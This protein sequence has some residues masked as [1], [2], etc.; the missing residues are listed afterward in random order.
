[1]AQGNGS[2]S[3]NSGEGAGQHTREIDEEYFSELDSADS[4]NDEVP[5]AFETDI[6]RG[7]GKRT[8]GVIVNDL[9]AERRL[10]NAKL[11]EQL[12]FLRSILPGT[13]P[14]VCSVTK[15]STDHSNWTME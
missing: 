12:S 9:H 3:H 6:P 15:T 13:T 14:G 8:Y 2:S 10:K 7:S 1:M 11:D 5:K 4:E